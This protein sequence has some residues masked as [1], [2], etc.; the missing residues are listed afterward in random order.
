MPTLPPNIEPSQIR[1]RSYIGYDGTG[2]A[3]RIHRGTTGRWVAVPGNSH[4][5]RWTA[6]NITDSTLASVAARLAARNPNINARR[7][8]LT[9]D[10]VS[11]VSC[12]RGWGQ[13]EGG[14]S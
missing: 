10:D 3:W 1:P 6:V 4:P 13:V 12:P 8:H 7:P 2:H 11:P 14:A 9:T 5:G